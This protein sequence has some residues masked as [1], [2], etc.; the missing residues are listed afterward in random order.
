MVRAV[1]LKILCNSLP[2]FPAMRVLFGVI[3]AAV[4]SAGATF[5]VRNRNGVGAVQPAG[6]IEIT[7]D[8]EEEQFV[9]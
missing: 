9:Q 6:E 1:A 7:G 8:E 2:K 3:L 5:I 4:L